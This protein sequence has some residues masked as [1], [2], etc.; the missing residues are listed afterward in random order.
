M[1]S[2]I[3]SAAQL[4]RR[5]PIYLQLPEIIEPS[6]SKLLPPEMAPQPES[7]SNQ[8]PLFL[9][10]SLKNYPNELPSNPSPPG[11]IDDAWIRLI[12]PPL[13]VLTLFKKISVYNDSANV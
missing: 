10:P 4:L 3:A 1:A 11:Q 8:S 12:L 7:S 6:S 2:S 13:S 9:T 5:L